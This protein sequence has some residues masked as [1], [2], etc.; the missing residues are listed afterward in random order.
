MPMQCFI[1]VKVSFERKMPVSPVEKCPFVVLAR[2]TIMLQHHL[3][4]LHNLP[5]GRFRD[6][7]NKGKFHTLSSKSGRGRL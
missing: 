5:S 2:N 3:F 1:C 7:Q 6:I 4:S